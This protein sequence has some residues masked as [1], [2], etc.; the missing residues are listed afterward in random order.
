MIAYQD[1]REVHLEISTLCNAACPQ[2]PRNFNGYPQNDGYPEVN[3]TLEMVKRIFPQEFLSRLNRILINGNFGD[4]VMN[5]ETLDIVRYFK[6]QAPNLKIVISTNGGARNREFWKA[7]AETNSTV[8]FCL[9]GLEDTHHL[10]RQN[11]SWSTVIKNAQTFIDAGGNATWKM[12]KFRHNEHQIDACRRLSQEMGFSWFELVDHGRDTGPVFDKNG[13]LTH[14]LG[15]Y[16]GST[17]FQ[18]V[19]YDYRSERQDIKNYHPRKSNI[20]GHTCETIEKRSIYVS[21]TGDVFPCC[22]TGMYPKTYGHNNYGQIT[23]DQIAPLIRENNALEYP[24]EH[25]IQWFSAVK[26]SWNIEKHV[27][28]RLLICDD[29][30]GC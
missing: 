9:D 15:D 29:V 11:T 22:F 19:F 18:V 10:Y 26:Q 24:L 1:I 13:N 17:D 5:P 14:V 6:Q 28:G 12:I 20:T 2:C 23:N 3:M 8:L 25:C 21:A 16:R 27:D 4:M 7:L 30:C